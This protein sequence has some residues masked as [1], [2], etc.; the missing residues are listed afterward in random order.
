MGKLKNCINCGAP[1]TGSRCD[2]CGTEYSENDSLHIELDQDAYTGVLSYGGK[3]YNV[4]LS[5]LEFENDGYVGR[6]MLGNC[7]FCNRTYRKF[8]LI[9]F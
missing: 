1:L 2:Y 8:T 6:D 4:Y 7:S 5:E 3:Q 9:E